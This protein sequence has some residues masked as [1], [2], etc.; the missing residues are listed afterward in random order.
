ML[1]KVKEL[2]SYASAL[3]NSLDKGALSVLAIWPVFFAFSIFFYFYHPFHFS[4]IAIA[5]FTTFLHALLIFFLLMGWARAEVIV[6]TLACFF[7]FFFAFS[8]YETISLNAILKNMAPY[9]LFLYPL[10]ISSFFSLFAFV[11]YCF[12]FFVLIIFIL[13]QRLYN[14]NFQYDF[15]EKIDID[16][17]LVVAALV[18]GN[19][20]VNKLIISLKE[21]SS[22]YQ[23]MRLEEKLKKHRKETFNLYQRAHYD[24]LTG[25][26]NREMTEEQIIFSVNHACKKEVSLG[27]LFIDLDDFKNI[28]DT[29]SHRAGDKCLIEVAT[30]LRKVFADLEMNNQK[31]NFVARIAG[32]EFI[33]V[34]T[35]AGKE[36]MKLLASELLKAART[37]FPITKE[38]NL[39][40]TLSIGAYLVE[41]EKKE[42]RDLLNRLDVHQLRTLLFTMADRNMY[43]AKRKKNMFHLSSFV[44]DDFYELSLDD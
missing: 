6:H 7:L 28:N 41:F 29:Y 23:K 9:W 35:G 32:D 38:K 4:S 31:S 34:F 33:I 40:V 1:A 43:I 10:L 18:C 27:I 16:E 12:V 19:V 8:F 44:R 26:Y 22:D 11:F 5:F 2:G 30:K 39:Q 37:P 21:I 24:F 17:I 15:F 36:K 20:I 13:G 42:V 25:L 3:L 14:L